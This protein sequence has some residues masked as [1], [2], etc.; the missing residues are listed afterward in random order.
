[1]LVAF[2]RE[3]ADQ[4]VVE[5][6]REGREA[7]ALRADFTREEEVAE[8]VAA[9]VGRWG[10]IDGLF[11]NAGIMPHEDV[12]VLDM[13][14]EV[15]SRVY[16]TNVRGTALCSKHAIPRILDAGGGAV[17]NMSSFVHVMGSTRPQDAYY[18]ASRG[19]VVSMSHS[20]A[21]QFGGRGVRVDALCPGPI[22][23]EHV[24]RN[25][26]DE[27][28]RRRRLDRI[29]LGRFGEPNDVAGL[30]LFLLSEEAGWITGQAILF[31]GGISC[32]YL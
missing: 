9:T 4:T 13:E 7:L 12:R 3:T 25:L 31:D 2:F 17:A 14:N 21:V 8:A 30:A 6:E 11:N 1:V 15:W 5:I 29:P 26:P 27:A 10:G 32:H 28:A 22:E 16:A 24:G 19:A 23:T 18:I 20:M